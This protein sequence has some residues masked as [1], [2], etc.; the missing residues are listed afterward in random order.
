MQSCRY[1]GGIKLMDD[2]MP[3]KITTDT[4]FALRRSQRA[5]FWIYRKPMTG[6]KPHHATKSQPAPQISNMHCKKQQLSRGNSFKFRLKD[7]Y[8]PVL[9][10]FVL[11]HKYAQTFPRSI[12]NLLNLSYFQ[13]LH[14]SSLF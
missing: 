14:Q 11:P 3:R 9:S 13:Y 7:Y 4:I 6:V 2:F 12:V 5:A 1:D 8:K 10:P